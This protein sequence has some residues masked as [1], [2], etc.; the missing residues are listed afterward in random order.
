MNDTNGQNRSLA[1]IIPILN[2]AETLSSLLNYLDNVGEGIDI[3]FVDGGSQDDTISRCASRGYRVIQATR[4]RASQMNAGADAIDAGIYWFV[5]A[6]CLP[7]SESLVAI[8]DSIQSGYQWGRF[9]VRLDDNHPIFRL[10]AMLMNWRSCLTAVATGDQ[11]I[12][13]TSELFTAIG[14]FPQI[15]LMEDIAISKALRRRGHMA[16][17]RSPMR[18]SA[19][20]WRRHGVLRTILLMWY[21]RLRYFFGDSPER[22]HRLYYGDRA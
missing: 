18:I 7:H 13:V 8:H 20:R 22:L 16:C 15:P 5:H 1:I 3:V 4:G 12:F 21:L 6:D 11:G 17:L 14:G 9:D 19:R 10:I 2:E